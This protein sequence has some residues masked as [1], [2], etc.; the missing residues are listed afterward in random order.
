MNLL[1]D[2]QVL[3]AHLRGEFIVPDDDSV[4]TTGYWYVRLCMAVQRSAG[5]S[6]S[7]PFA[8]L[9]PTLR[10]A[11]IAAVLTLPD[12]IGLLSLRQLGPRIGGLATGH[13]PMNI[14]SREALAAALELAA[15]VVFAAGNENPT[16]QTALRAEA[17]PSR[18]VDLRAAR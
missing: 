7:R 5:G 9:P 14:L 1:V 2:D 17:L 10:P 11:A 3:A 13:P 6:L 8:A 18:V 16:L 12:E 15:T 4:H